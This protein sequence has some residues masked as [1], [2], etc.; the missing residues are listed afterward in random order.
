M[1]LH[2]FFG[3][4][5]LIGSIVFHESLLDRYKRKGNNKAML[6]ESRASGFSIGMLWVYL[7]YILLK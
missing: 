1:E 7:G 3:I 6:F 5:F 4:V 2:E